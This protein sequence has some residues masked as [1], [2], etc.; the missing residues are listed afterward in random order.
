MFYIGYEDIDTAR[1]CVAKSKNGI[2]G[3][4]RS[5]LNPLVEPTAGAWDSD[6]TYKPTVLWNEEKEKWMLWYNGRTAGDEYMGYAYYPMRDLFPSAVKG[7][8]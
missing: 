1:I 2:T 7:E 5:T 4:E 3:W 8:D 6:A